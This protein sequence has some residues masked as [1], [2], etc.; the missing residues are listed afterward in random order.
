MSASEHWVAN[1]SVTTPN[2]QAAPFML[3]AGL[4]WYW[5]I[6]ICFLLL[7]LCTIWTHQ[8]V[9]PRQPGWRRL[10]AATP[11]VTALIAAPFLID[12]FQEPILSMMVTF[13][14]VRMPVTKLLAACFGRGPL[15]ALP[16]RPTTPHC[17]SPAATLC[18]WMRFSALWRE[19]HQ[20][21]PLSD[22]GEGNGDGVGPAAAPVPD[23]ALITFFM[24]CPV[25]PRPSRTNI[26]VCR[27]N[28]A[29]QEGAWL[30]Y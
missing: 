22:E 28:K 7:W 14:S 2:G 5:R 30:P 12:P 16:L 23:L 18:R 13:M 6:Q 3:L 19:K 21:F 15:T 10:R 17:K 25:V 1:A 11:A 27:G 8:V 26:N 24:L 4:S 9:L 20:Q 29:A